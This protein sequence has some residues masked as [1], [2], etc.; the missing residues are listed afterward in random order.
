MKTALVTGATSGFGLAICKTL[1]QAGYK[2]IGTGR[3]LERLQALKAE[4]G[5]HFLPLAFDVS[6]A[7]QTTEVLNNRPEGWQ[8]VDLLVNNA[9]LALGLEPAHKTDLNDWYQMID[10]NIKGLVTVTRLILPE[11]V[12][13]NV[14]HIINLGSIAGSYAYPGGNV[15]GGTKAFVKQFSLNLRADLAGTAIRVSNVEPGLCGGTEF[16]NVRFKGD[17]EK[18]AKVYENVQFVT[19]EDIAEIVLWLNQQPP[20][21]N[22]NRIEV[23]P[24]AQSFAPLSVARS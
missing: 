1:I 20:H 3:R 16:S 13:R 12:A 5:E 23:M 18:A 4:L 15:Y 24:V 19:P 7:E 6:N 11:M 2:V 10:T 14:G 8:Q 9:G 17:D 22:I 21:V